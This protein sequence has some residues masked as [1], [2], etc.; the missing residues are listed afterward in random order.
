MNDGETKPQKKA[1]FESTCCVTFA[2]FYQRRKVF[3]GVLMEVF[4]YTVK[5]LVFVSLT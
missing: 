1:F 2:L 4:A 3:L 5:L